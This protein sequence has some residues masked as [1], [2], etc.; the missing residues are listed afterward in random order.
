MERDLGTTSVDTNVRNKC[1]THFA[2]SA[3]QSV[4]RKEIYP[5]RE[6]AESEEESGA[7]WWGGGPRVGVMLA[8]LEAISRWLPWP[9]GLGP[10]PAGGRRCCLTRLQPS[11]HLAD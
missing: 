11:A 6:R 4:S 3:R 10:P 8:A 9:Q 5:S 7:S 2:K 1:T